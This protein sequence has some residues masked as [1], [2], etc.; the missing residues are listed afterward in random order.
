MSLR[1]PSKSL[2]G[3]HSSRIAGNL[4]S[5][6]YELPRT[7]TSR[8]QHLTESRQDCEAATTHPTLRQLLHLPRS[9]RAL[10]SNLR[11][12][13]SAAGTSLCGGLQERIEQ[14]LGGCRRSHGIHLTS[15]KLRLSSKARELYYNAL[16]HTRGEHLT[17]LCSLPIT[18]WVPGKAN[19][20]SPFCP[21]ARETEPESYSRE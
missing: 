7:C 12:L 3:Q 1:P 2:R 5:T 8:S 15:S 16:L 19:R 13:D 9:I 17:T 11:P 14:I 10:L 18:F 20:C 4:H 21:C 6:S